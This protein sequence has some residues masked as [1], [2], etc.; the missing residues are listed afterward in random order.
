MFLFLLLLLG[1]ICFSST[2][3]WLCFKASLNIFTK[4]LW[5]LLA[6][7]NWGELVSILCSYVPRCNA[8]NIMYVYPKREEIRI[9]NFSFLPPQNIIPAPR[10]LSI[11]KSISFFIIFKISKIIQAW[12]KISEI[13]VHLQTSDTSEMHILWHILKQG[14]LSLIIR[15]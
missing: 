7:R 12:V 5:C 6:F 10:K 13:H 9:R 1:G 3:F 11:T 8:C 2:Y 14:V 4:A 15:T